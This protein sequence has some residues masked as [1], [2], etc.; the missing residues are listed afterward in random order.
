MLT[1]LDLD[2][3]TIYHIHCLSKISGVDR[4][5]ILFQWKK[6]SGHLFAY[7]TSRGYNHRLNKTI[8]DVILIVLY[9]IC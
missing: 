2:V 9:Q 5:Q 7:H 3:R 1:P 6:V 8:S 4:M